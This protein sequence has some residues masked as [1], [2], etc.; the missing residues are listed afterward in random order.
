MGNV[1]KASSGVRSFRRGIGPTRSLTD[2]LPSCIASS[3]FASR[4]CGWLLLL[5][6]GGPPVTRVEAALP[7][8]HRLMREV[9]V[10]E[11]KAL[12]DSHNDPRPI[13][14]SAA[15][16]ALSAYRKKLRQSAADLPSLG[17]VAGVLLLSEWTS[18]EI[19]IEPAVEAVVREPNEEAF[20]RD[21]QKL[22]KMAG[23]NA[24][25]V[26]RAFVAAIK[27]DVRLLLVKRLE[28]RTRFYLNEGR[29]DSRIAAAN[30]ISDI[31]TLSS[32]QEIP[33]NLRSD[34]RLAGKVS[35]ASAG[36]LRERLRDLAGDVR[37]LLAAPDAQVQVAGARALSDL[38]IPAAELAA[39][40]KPVFTSPGADVLTRRAVADALAHVLELNSAR[41]EGEAAPDLESSNEAGQDRRASEKK[42]PP[43]TSLVVVE[44]ILPVAVLGL[45]DNDPEVRGRSLNACRRA[46]MIL[47]DLASAPPI[48][49]RRL[50]EKR[51]A[52]LHQALKVVDEVLPK[53]TAAA[54]DQVPALRVA[55]CRTL[56]TFALAGLRVRNPR[57]QRLPPPILDMP[58]D[59][60]L[61]KEGDKK[62]KGV[63][64]PPSRG[65]KRLVAKR[66]SQ[67]AATRSEPRGG[68]PSSPLLPLPVV[69]D[70]GTAGV[71]LERPVQLRDPHPAAS[72]RR[73]PAGA[74]RK[75]PANAGRSPSSNGMVRPVSFLAPQLGD[76][77]SPTP[78]SDSWQGTVQTMIT[79]LSDPDYRVR[80]GA[81]DVL[82]TLVDGAEPAIPAMVKALADTN[83]F[84]RWS[85]ARTLGRFATRRKDKSDPF[86]TR[87]AES[88]V[89]GLM[90]LLNDREDPSVRIT[91]A[92]ALEQYGETAT[93]A[94]PHLARVINRGDKDYIIA[95]LHTIQGIGSGAAPTLPN[96]AWVLSDRTQPT[97]VRVEAALTLGRFGPVAK[98]QPRVMS[99]L[100]DTML[101]D[102]N[103][104]VRNAASTAI[105]SIERPLK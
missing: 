45:D 103:S 80:L 4:R 50:E 55:A 71:T 94:V 79:N 26:R 28:S 27:S 21:V 90:A 35:A 86:Y 51:L 88:A 1:G 39:T 5:L 22:M 98:T 62:N 10:D 65:G 52:D 75:Q 19:D 8:E 44:Q 92:Y 54:R 41:G 48:S 60:D 33:D 43:A 15:G 29:N 81:V 58:K 3:G 9:G 99:V 69:R 84:V 14:A 25:D 20:Q 42:L 34:T 82:E 57:E 49:R 66:P 70:S 73:Q 7:G 40:F 102:T 61:P 68:S 67:W 78:V 12:I 95:I 74:S 31:M 16:P 91:A 87:Y 37:K 17:A 18:E 97:S 56:E 77:P 100:R 64:L 47:D 38:G 30:L 13:D 53:I 46:A 85:A 2:M 59:L 83:K 24:N 89:T 93:K 105:L 36:Y 76:L 11:F 101:N 23:D 63:S 96:V 72:E 104:D 32:R 6:L